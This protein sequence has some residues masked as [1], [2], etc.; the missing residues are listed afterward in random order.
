MIWQDVTVI[1]GELP[2]PDPTSILP[3][4]LKSL[5]VKEATEFLADSVT[6]PGGPDSDG[7]SLRRTGFVGQ[8]LKYKACFPALET[9]EVELKRRLVEN[10]RGLLL[11]KELSQEAE[12]LGVSLTFCR[13]KD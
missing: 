13:H 8:I 11:L 3:R 4:Q 7:K 10:S 12:Q 5:K 9:I 1:Q 6:T 2:P